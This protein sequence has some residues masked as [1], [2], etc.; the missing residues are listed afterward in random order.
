MGLNG[1][2][3][4]V[5]NDAVPVDSLYPEEFLPLL[6]ATLRADEKNPDAEP[7]WHKSVDAAEWARGGDY[8]DEKSS[9]HAYSYASGCLGRAAALIR[10][11]PEGTNLDTVRACLIAHAS[12]ASREGARPAALGCIHCAKKYEKSPEGR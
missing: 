1:A 11:L 10:D 6:Q 7:E 9:D 8:L 3:S 5:T 2:P 12:A 4:V